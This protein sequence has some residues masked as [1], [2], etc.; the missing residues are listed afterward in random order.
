MRILNRTQNIVLAEGAREAKTWREKARGLLGE[1]EAHPI[2]IRTRWGIHTVGMRFP[3][4]VVIMDARHCVR[5]LRSN[6]KPGSFFFWN[7]R[8]MMVLE[9]PL[10][11][12]RATKISLGD[13]LEIGD[14]V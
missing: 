13:I 5:V 4:D 9:L 12:I 7:P 2:L 8:Y 3:I 1:R 11:M 10:G 14:S 6:L